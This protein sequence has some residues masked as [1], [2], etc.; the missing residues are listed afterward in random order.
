M[1]VPGNEPTSS[2]PT[3]SPSSPNRCCNISAV[4][5]RVFSFFSSKARNVISIA[6]KV[7]AGGRSTTISSIYW[8]GID[9]RKYHRRLCVGR[10]TRAK[11]LALMQPRPPQRTIFV[12]TAARVPAVDERGWPKPTLRVPCCAKWP[13]VQL[14]QPRQDD[15]ED[16]GISTEIV[17]AEVYRLPIFAFRRPA[18]NATI[19]PTTRWLDLIN[20][21]AIPGARTRIPTIS[22]VFVHSALAEVR[23]NEL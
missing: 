22:A 2:P 1:S 18:R 6:P 19:G 15:I 3:K 7:G 23:K 8:P 21:C 5:R 10:N 14:L 16:A 20:G 11:K 13:F 17:F 12:Q 9:H 4:N